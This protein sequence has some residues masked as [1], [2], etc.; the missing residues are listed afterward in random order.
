MNPSD[1]HRI[2]TRFR[3]GRPRWVTW[4]MPRRLS[5]MPGVTRELQ[6]RASAKSLSEEQLLRPCQGKDVDKA[7]TFERKQVV[8]VLR[9]LDYSKAD[10]TCMLAGV[11]FVI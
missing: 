4:R 2:F 6:R 8:T 11:T 3:V 7:W 9:N 1:E 5:S 10:V